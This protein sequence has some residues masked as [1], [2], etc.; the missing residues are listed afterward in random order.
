MYNSDYIGSELRVKDLR[1]HLSGA[2]TNIG[3]V[4][5]VRSSDTFAYAFG[6]SAA[7][8][9]SKT[10]SAGTKLTVLLVIV[11]LSELSNDSVEVREVAVSIKFKSIE[12]IGL[13]SILY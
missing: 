4:L 10:E 6:E 1:E 9:E 11:E 5:S 7:V 12:V 8:R 3:E 2:F 13:S